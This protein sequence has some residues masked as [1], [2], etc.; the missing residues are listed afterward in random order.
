MGIAHTNRTGGQIDSGHRA[1]HGPDPIE[2]TEPVEG[3]PVVARP[4]VGPGQSRAEFLTAD[5]TRVE[6]DTDDVEAARQTDRSEH[7]GIAESGDHHAL[8]VHVGGRYRPPAGRRIPF[9]IVAG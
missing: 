3:D 1:V 8:S 2:F 5:Q 9:P 4:V 6:R 7:A